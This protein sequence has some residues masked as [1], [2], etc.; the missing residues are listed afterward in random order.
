MTNEHFGKLVK[1]TAK[2]AG[3]R[4]AFWTH[5]TRHTFI[6]D[7]LRSGTPITLV[8]QWVGHEDPA[9]TLGYVAESR[10]NIREEYDKAIRREASGKSTPAERTSLPRGFRPRRSRRGAA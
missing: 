1:A 4:K 7:R 10:E 3:I 5:L 6:T 9:T 2:E 8:S